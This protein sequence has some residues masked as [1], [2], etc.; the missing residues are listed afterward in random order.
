MY[1]SL[2]LSPLEKYYLPYYLR[3]D[4]AGMMH[5]NSEYQLIY[6]LNDARDTRLALDSDVQTGQSPQVVGKALPFQLSAQALQKGDRFLWRESLRSYQNKRF[7]TFSLAGFIADLRCSTCL[8][9]LSCVGRSLSSCS[10]LFRS[11]RTSDVGSNCA[12]G[13][14][15]KALF[16]Y[17]ELSSPRLWRGM[18]SGLRWMAK[19]ATPHP[20]AAENK[21]ILTVGDTGAGKS[22]IIRQILFQVAERGHSAIVYDPACE[23]IQQFYDERRGDIVLNPLDPAARIG[24]LRTKLQRKAEAKAIAVSLFQPAGITNRFFVESPQKVFAHLL[25]FLPTPTQ[26]IEWM[27]HPEEIDKRVRE[28]NWRRSS[29]PGAKSADGCSWLSQH[30]G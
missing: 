8:K 22:T 23:F 14:A 1:A 26:L 20:R 13:D 19:E 12:M 21:H 24:V 3:T 4:T 15:S 17:R 28:R 30:G 27:S 10:Y 11:G 6:V 29:I 5:Q 18:G 25:S 9:R 2:W 16:W 7:I